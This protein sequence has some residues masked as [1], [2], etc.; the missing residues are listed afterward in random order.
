MG[1]KRKSETFNVK[2]VQLQQHGN[3]YSVECRKTYPTVSIRK[4]LTIGTARLVHCIFQVDILY[5]DVHTMTN[6]TKYIILLL[7]QHTCVH[8]HKCI[9]LQIIDLYLINPKTPRLFPS[10]CHGSM[11]W[12]WDGQKDPKPFL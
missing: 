3:T 6:Y 2:A 4:P 5:I 10:R 1:Q 8:I 7:L 12:G 9:F 11:G